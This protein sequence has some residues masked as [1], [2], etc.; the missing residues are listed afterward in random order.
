MSEKFVLNGE[1]PDEQTGGGADLTGINP[2]NLEE[3][4]SRLAEPV[5]LRILQ[6][7]TTEAIHPLQTL[8]PS[9]LRA[10]ADNPNLSP[11]DLTDKGRRDLR[12]RANE[13]ERRSGPR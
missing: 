7:M 8:T 3:M 11:T 5:R 6:N 2:D 10:I 13:I 12:N 9:D 4:N 1:T